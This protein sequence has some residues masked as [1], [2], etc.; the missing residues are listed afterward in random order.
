MEYSNQKMTPL[1]LLVVA[2]HLP[3]YPASPLPGQREI[4]YPPW[5]TQTLTILQGPNANKHILRD[6]LKEFHVKKAGQC[7]ARAHTQ[8]CNVNM[9]SY[10]IP[11]LGIRTCV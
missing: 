10:R 6:S 11:K 1:A 9:K 2:K 8:T 3:Y 7:I 5:Q 4:V